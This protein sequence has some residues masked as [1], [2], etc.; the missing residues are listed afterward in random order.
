M[1]HAE[2]TRS[3]LVRRL[4][5][6]KQNKRDSY[7]IPRRK[8]AA[9]CSIAYSLLEKQKKKKEEEE[10]EGREKGQRRRNNAS[11]LTHGTGRVFWGF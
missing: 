9:M 4:K 2:M 7:M 5:T 1:C 11:L 10:E 8:M 6:T 3:T